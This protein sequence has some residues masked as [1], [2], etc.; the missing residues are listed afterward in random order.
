MYKKKQ[1]NKSV[2]TVKPSK[3]QDT[4]A[5]WLII[6]FIATN[7]FYV[8]L[9][10]WSL[11]LVRYG[12]RFSKI[13][14]V[15]EILRC[16]GFK[17]VNASTAWHIRYTYYFLEISRYVSRKRE[18]KSFGT[19][20]SF[21]ESLGSPNVNCSNEQGK[22]KKK[23][24]KANYIYIYTYSNIIRVYTYVRSDYARG[25]VSRFAAKKRKNENTTKNIRVSTSRVRI[26]TL[27]FPIK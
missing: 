27:P 11:F 18:S 12:F 2:T 7:E 10:A 14:S 17:R 16:K 4:R 22:E 25:A 21:F 24:L 26:I 20:Y 1:K 13:R 19:I 15:E 9:E 8:G 3:E 5:K 23:S 6:E